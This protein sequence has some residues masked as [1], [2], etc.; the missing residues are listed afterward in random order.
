MV[1]CI[2]MVMS[3]HSLIITGHDLYCHEAYL[4][5]GRH[6]TAKKVTA[7]LVGGWTGVGK[8]HQLSMAVITKSF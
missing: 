1:G 7:K 3:D 6:W 2:I 8:G 4:V 5:V